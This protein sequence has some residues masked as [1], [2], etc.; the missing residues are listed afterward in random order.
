MEERLSARRLSALIDAGL[1]LAA[2]LDLD[3][4]L[5]RIAD[6]SR[7][8]IGAKYGAVGVL[9]EDGTLVKFHHSGI[10]EET[11]LKIGNLPEGRGVLGA[12][13]EEGKPLRLHEISDHAR[14]YG[15][16][17]NHPEMHSFLGVPIVA[18][19]RIFGRLY[20]TEKHGA[21]GF[22]KDDERLALVFAAQ[23]GVAVENARLYGQVQE[24]SEELA[25]RLAEL[26]SVEVIGKLLMSETSAEEMFR[27]VAE[28]ARL[29]TRGARSSIA[30][31]D[32]V[33]GDLLVRMAVGDQV[34]AELAG[35]RL[36]AG[37]SKAHGVMQR[38]KGEVVEDLS[39][40]SEV[41]PATWQLLGRPRSGVFAPLVVKGR[42]VGTLGVYERAGGRGFSKDDL[43]ILD[44]LAGMAAIALENERLNEA[45]RDLA[46]LEERERISKELH[47]G[48]I[49]SI[50]SVGLSLQG[51]VTL[52][53][54]DP[55][56]AKQRIDQS[57][58]ELD[59][60]VRDVRGYI[61]EL[62]PRIVEEVGLTEALKELVREL[63]INTLAHTTVDLD[64]E[65]CESLGEQEQVHVVQVVREVL[66]N[67]A[68]HAQASEVSVRCVH[69]ADVLIL[70]IEDDGIGFHPEGVSRGHGLS[71]ISDRAARLNGSIE[72]LERQPKGTTHR[73]RVPLKR[74]EATRGD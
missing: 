5:Q 63:E 39:Q 59:N 42:G 3:A 58:A 23:A 22:S 29:L 62:R 21:A 50:Y 52:L 30:L 7:E 13:I 18:R 10:D 16:P 11:V 20:L 25:H 60:V 46:V 12:L 9:D 45:L 2:E 68:R 53:G 54:R 28:E 36:P 38:M 26:S 73:L 44:L 35:K 57:I 15:F 32:P 66:S 34:A 33:T 24:R 6:L 40:D 74:D 56:M 27:T 65:A 61:F 70:T 72:I 69:E 43:A 47:D 8:V 14:S 71:N 31:H 64:N 41:D 19:K 4:L 67:I 55:V 37:T 51:S 48:V 1:A 49:Q 17:S